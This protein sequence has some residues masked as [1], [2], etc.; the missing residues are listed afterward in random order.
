[1]AQARNMK[2]GVWRRTCGAGSVWTLSSEFGTTK[3][4]KAI[5]WPWLEPF[6]RKMFLK[7]FK[8]FHSRSAAERW[9]R[10]GVGSDLGRDVTAVEQTRYIQDSPDQIPV[11]AFG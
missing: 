2:G 1:M 5:S 10:V 9:R 4:V 8:F 11:L 7:A 6:C 3:T